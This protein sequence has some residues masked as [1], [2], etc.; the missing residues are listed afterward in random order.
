MGVHNSIKTRV[1]QKTQLSISWDAHATWCTILQ[2]FQYITNFDVEDMLV[3]LYYWF[4]KS[5]KQKNVLAEFCSF[6][7]TEYR[8][9]VKHVSTCWLSLECAVE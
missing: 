7:N 1:H 3:D 2:S 8:Q 9:V 5:K 6:C 4:D